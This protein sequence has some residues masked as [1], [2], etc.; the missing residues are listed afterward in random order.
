MDLVH[1]S[2]LL[3]QGPTQHHWVHAVPKTSRAV[4]E[5]INLT[6]RYVV[7]SAP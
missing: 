3:M 7:P 4:G 1:G 5:R 6:F 2:L